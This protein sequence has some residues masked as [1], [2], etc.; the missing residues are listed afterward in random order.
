M[1]RNS[2][3]KDERI[4]FVHRKGKRKTALQRSIEN[5]EDYRKKLKEYTNKIHLCG[6]RNSYSKTDTDA[7]TLIPFLESMEKHLNFN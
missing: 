1:L 5:L 3:K 6:N 2:T 4:E 7:T